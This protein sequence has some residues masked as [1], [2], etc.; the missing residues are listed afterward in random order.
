MSWRIS[1]R[2]RAPEGRRIVEVSGLSLVARFSRPRS[3]GPAHTEQSR[4]DHCGQ[5]SARRS[6]RAA[7]PG[8]PGHPRYFQ[9]VIRLP[10]DQ[11]PATPHHLRA[12]AQNL[13]L[14]GLG[15]P[16]HSRV[17]S[18][19]A[20]KTN[21]EWS[22]YRSHIRPDLR[23]FQP[24]H[25]PPRAVCLGRRSRVLGSVVVPRP[26]RPRIAAPA[27]T[28]R[29]C[30]GSPDPPRLLGGMCGKA[31]CDRCQVLRSKRVLQLASFVAFWKPS[32]EFES[33]LPLRLIANGF[34][35]RARSSALMGCL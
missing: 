12:S 17:P 1:N 25:P 4:I 26:R 7:C 32:P 16:A 3:H 8:F 2:I 14:L 5:R 34:S 10:G 27:A 6:R 31:R 24:P 29:F 15:D 22:L 11:F 9:P 30:G 23:P 33:F 19:S 20:F 21:R 28:H 13:V 18:S 35:I